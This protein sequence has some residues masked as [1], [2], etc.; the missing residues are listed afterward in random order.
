MA[1]QAAYQA[2]KYL[3]FMS[4]IEACSLVRLTSPEYAAA[5]WLHYPHQDHVVH[6]ITGMG[7]RNSATLVR[8][9]CRTVSWDEQ[10]SKLALEKFL[11]SVG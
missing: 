2:F 11:E 9:S 5:A 4:R 6:A 7:L 3:L 10:E 1:R 8:S